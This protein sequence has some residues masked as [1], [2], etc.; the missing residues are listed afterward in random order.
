MANGV[1]E[2]SAESHHEGSD[3]PSAMG[4]GHLHAGKTSRIAFVDEQIARSAKIAI[5]AGYSLDSLEDL[6]HGVKKHTS[7]GAT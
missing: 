2:D 1:L 3:G 5:H 4:L 7:W 6:P